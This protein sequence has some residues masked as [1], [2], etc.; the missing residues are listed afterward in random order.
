[1]TMVPGQ[2][3]TRQSLIFPIRSV[4]D[5]TILIPLKYGMIWKIENTDFVGAFYRQ[6]SF[7]CDLYDSKTRELVGKR[8]RG[9]Y[10]MN[11]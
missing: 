8:I 7:D 1:M 6:D 11:K 3:T 5:D 9:R 10:I 2:V 4:D